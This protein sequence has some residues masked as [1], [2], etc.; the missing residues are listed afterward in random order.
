[1]AD[2]CLT[3]AVKENVLI[4]SGDCSVTLLPEF[5]G[6]IA[7]ICVRNREL[8]QAPLA[9]I[10]PRTR[11]MAFEKSD[12]SGWDECLPSV[13]ACEVETERG[14]AK[15]PDHGDLWRVGWEVQGP[16]N[17]NR[18]PGT[19]GVAEGA[20]GRRRG[21]A[22]ITLKGECFSLP[23]SLERKLVLE[24]TAKGCELQFD[25][26]LTNRGQVQSPWS[27]AAHPLFRVE[28]GDT[29]LLPDSI[30]A[31][32]VEGSRGA[33]LGSAGDEASWPVASTK[34]GEADLRAVQAERS[35]IAEKLFAG[36]L[37]PGEGWC[38]LRR[39][40]AGVNIR[41][42]F[43]PKA[44]PFLGVWLCYGGWPERP[45]PKQMCAA[46]EPATA[47]VDS[48]AKGGK[49]TKVLE[50]GDSA[51]W[52]LTVKIEVSQVAQHA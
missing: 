4:Q 8:L 18:V 13:A 39:P 46:L 45:G 38:E 24:R 9:E 48:L 12:A 52:P 17:A 27:W 3:R 16:V 25:Y 50:P 2:G 1:M 6:K 41:F 49:W 51:A 7:S 23:L 47:P 26:K 29:I 21:T 5:G 30:R 35:G 33:R 15:I 44:T 11:T 22:S 36:P 43:D 37:K 42:S 14:A 28:E 19:K 32:K 31:V 10:G 20:A 34:D 40:K